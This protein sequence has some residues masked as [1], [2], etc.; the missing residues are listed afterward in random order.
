MGYSDDA[1]VIV[2]A[3]RTP[4]GAFNG[5]H[6]DAPAHKLGA[7]AIKSLLLRT[8][9]AGSDVSEVIIGQIIT[10]YNG[11][12][13]A[14]QA[15]INAGVPKEVTAYGIN[16]LCGSGLKA[17]CLGYQAIK[18]GD[19]KIV[20]AGGQENMSRSPH[21]YPLRHAKNYEFIDTM[22][23]DALIDPFYN[24]NMVTT[25]ENIANLFKISREEQDEFAAESQNK[26]EAARKKGKFKDEIVPISYENGGAQLIYLHDELP[27]N[28]VSSD[29]LSKLQAVM[30]KKGSV[31]AGNASGISDGAS[32]VM[33]MSYQESKARG[34][35]PMAAIKSFAEAGVDPSIMG[36][37]PIPASKK[38]LEKANWTVDDLDLIEANE[39]FASQ[40]IHVNR[41]M[42]WDT[43]KVNVN[44]GAIAMGH[45]FGASGARVL[46]TLVHEMKRQDAKK[47]L[48]T[49]C[50][51]GG[52][53]ITICLESY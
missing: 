25:A 11:P 36:I 27:K 16:Q 49:L 21:A 39:A 5:I 46:T 9:V 20:I 38:A 28:G 1:I 31:T 51:G 45:P 8:S 47:A 35:K 42:K 13:P 41:E 15:A 53:G 40:A 26:C 32:V 23:H 50:M 14:R 19:S 2:D 4:I 18:N 34:L 22:M 3:V 37:A 43:K 17:I 7:E 44:G 29:S 12:N 52:M 33:L 30:R 6:K 10:A 48:A 24:I